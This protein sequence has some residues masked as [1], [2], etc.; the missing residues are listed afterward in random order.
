MPFK[1]EK[2]EKYMF[3]NHPKIAKQWA[4]EYGNA[5]EPPKKAA[6]TKTKK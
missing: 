2:Q 6:A 1:S 3:A 4:K 5:K